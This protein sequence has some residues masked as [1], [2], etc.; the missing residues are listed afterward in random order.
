MNKLIVILVALCLITA[1]N[2]EVEQPFTSNYIYLSDPV[3][4]A[5]KAIEKGDF[6]FYA[7]NGVGR[8]IP[9]I[10]RKCITN[11]NQIII[12]E[13]TSEIITSYKNA[14]FNVIAGLYAEYYN[15]TIESYLVIQGNSCFYASHKD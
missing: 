10:N 8:S 14:Q 11:G 4:D 5:E 13:G 7:I 12:I 1:C 15:D 3:D 6:R 2:E 9:G